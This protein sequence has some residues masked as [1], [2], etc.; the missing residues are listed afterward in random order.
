MRYDSNFA[1]E[2]KIENNKIFLSKNDIPKFWFNI[3]PLLP[4]SLEPPISPLTKKAVTFEELALIFPPQLIE[5]EISNKNEIPIPEEVLEILSIFRPT[6]LVRAKHLEKELST[7][8]RI[9][10]KNEGVSP[11][12]AHKANTAVA[13]AYYNKVAGIR[14]LST[15]TGAGQWGSALSFACNRFGLDLR[16]F[17]VKISLEQKPL[18]SVLMKLYGAEVVASPSLLTSFGRKVLEKEPDCIGS[19]GIAISEAVEEAAS[20]KD[21]NY[22]LGSVLNHVLLHQTVIGLEAKRQLEAANEKADLIIGCHGGGSNFGGLAIPFIRDIIEGEKIEAIA[23]EPT[24]CPTLTKGIYAY[25]YGDTA[26]IT[27]IM[28]MF[29]LGSSFMPPSAHAGG[30]RYHG[31]SPLI[32][33]LKNDG[34]IKAESVNQNEVFKAALL[35]AQTEGII[36]APESAHAIAFVI[37]KAKQMK[38][39]GK[40][41]VILFC[42]SGH[43]LFDMSAYK[44]FLEGGLSDSICPEKEIAESL[45][46]LPKV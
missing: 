18:R 41:G 37:R 6:P 36:P 44:S 35:F 25:D 21:T 24:S 13:Q 42:L 3:K 46:N 34:I 8:A 9:Y 20:R 16:V 22:A 1:E 39:E 33:A 10:F 26:G 15:E 7:P 28:K 45:K 38:E 32:S 43:G 23:V 27:P 19:L 30:L 40:E 17:M 2:P 4:F 11:T 31:A 5:Q 12:G 29:T 14:R